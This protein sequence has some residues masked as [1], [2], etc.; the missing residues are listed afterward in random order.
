[1]QQD[2]VIF[3]P[4]FGSYATF[5]DNEYWVG[6]EFTGILDADGFTDTECAQAQIDGII[7]PSGRVLVKAAEELKGCVVRRRSIMIHVEDI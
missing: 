6:W 3:N 4:E 2:Y 5:T 7:M 1:M